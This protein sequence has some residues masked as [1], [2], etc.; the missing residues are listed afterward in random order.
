MQ[1]NE[2]LHVSTPRPATDVPQTHRKWVARPVP[3]SCWVRLVHSCH[4]I[5]NYDN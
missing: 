5:D 1:T 3:W 4:R 2:M